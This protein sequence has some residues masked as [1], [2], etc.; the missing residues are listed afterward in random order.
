MV[1]EEDEEALAAVVVVCL[2]HGMLDKLG[3]RLTILT[4][5][6]GYAPQGPP[7]SVL[8][9]IAFIRSPPGMR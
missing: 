7:A 6:G 4:G 5:R 8:G 9:K 2:L 1:V 3:E